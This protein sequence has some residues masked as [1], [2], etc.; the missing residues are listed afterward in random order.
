VAVAEL[1]IEA[2]WAGFD[3]G[4]YDRAVHHFTTAL[5]L[6]TEAQDAYLQ[7]TAAMVNHPC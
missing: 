7:S 3:V 6:A 5:E 4:R 1:H 2:G